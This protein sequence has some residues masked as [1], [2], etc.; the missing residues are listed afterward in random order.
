[1]KLNQPTKLV[2]YISLFLGFVGVLLFLAEIITPWNFWMVAVAWVLLVL[3]T[4][5]K[6]L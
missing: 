5:L 2:W 6:G 4:L 1:M 3:G